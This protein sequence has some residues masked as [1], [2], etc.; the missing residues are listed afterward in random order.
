MVDVDE[1]TAG[2][3]RA[4]VHALWASVAQA[5][6]ERA[7]ETDRRAAAITEAMLDGAEVGS[8]DRILELACGPGG[9]GLAAAAR[10]GP[11]G[12]VVLSDVADEMVAVAAARARARGLVEVET[13][14]LDLEAIDQ[15]DR[16]YD[17]VLCRDGL[18]F[19]V[20][21]LRAL[22]EMHRVLRDGGRIAI[23]V[24]G[25]RAR[26]PWLAVVLDA[27]SEQIGV[28][29]PPPGVPGPFSLGDADRLVDLLVAAGFADVEVR[30]F[31]VPLRAPSFDAFWSRT[32]T[33]AGPVAS[34]VAGMSTDD[35]AALVE[36]V[37]A[38]VEP[39]HSS[40]GIELPG[41]ALLATAARA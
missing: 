17:R 25:P 8:G 34:I 23:V 13:A 39:Y 31:D 10:V 16:S 5:W 6:A 1:S 12:A 24:W 21:P 18:M 20:D 26:N 22:G 14:T 33:L 36:R 3:V 29:M 2:A 41:V 35:R 7:D 30:E 4:G 28:P 38:A 11:H 37:R 19:A 32:S 9:A 27:V 15:P 40:A